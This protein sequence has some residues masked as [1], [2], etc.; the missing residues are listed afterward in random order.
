MKKNYLIFILIFIQCIN[1]FKL[2][3]KPL[4]PKNFL[5]QRNIDKFNPDVVTLT[6]DPISFGYN[7][8]AHCGVSAILTYIINKKDNYILSAWTISYLLISKEWFFIENSKLLIDNKIYDLEKVPIEP[9][10]E[11]MENGNIIEKKSFILSNELISAIEN[12]NSI[13]IRI[14]GKTHI[15]YNLNDIGII[16]FKKFIA[17]VKNNNEYIETTATIDSGVVK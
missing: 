11:V 1:S 9:Y 16:L 12:C 15:D 10:R 6:F 17:L 4:D 8:N 7:L 13:S 5:L 2:E 14:S 3:S